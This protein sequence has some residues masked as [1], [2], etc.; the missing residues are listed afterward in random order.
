MKYPGRV[1]VKISLRRKCLPAFLLALIS[2]L[3][4]QD[5]SFFCLWRARDKTEGFCLYSDVLFFIA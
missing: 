1:D 3:L 4:S 2:H 5:I